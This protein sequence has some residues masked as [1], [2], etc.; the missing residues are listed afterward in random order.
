MANAPT[1]L[2]KI[3]ARTAAIGG[4]AVLLAGCYEAKQQATLYPND[5][6]PE[7]R[8]AVGAA[9]EVPPAGAPFRLEAS[10]PFGLETTVAIVAPAPLDAAALETVAR[11][12]SRPAQGTLRGIAVRPAP[13]A[14]PSGSRGLVWNA[15]TVL[16]RP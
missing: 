6:Q 8:I 5:Y 3:A 16:V 4:L 15:V 14:G 2:T 13:T 10:P 11:G 7:A 1:R 12:L 9:L